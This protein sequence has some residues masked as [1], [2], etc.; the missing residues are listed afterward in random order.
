[1]NQ[2]TCLSHMEK[3]NFEENS[4]QVSLSLSLSQY[5]NLSMRNNH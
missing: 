2:I 5:S 1:M 3:R 4:I